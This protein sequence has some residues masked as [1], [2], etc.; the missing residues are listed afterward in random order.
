MKR[1]STVLGRSAATGRFVLRPA[2]KQNSISVMKAK[3]AA[4][5]VSSR[6]R[7]SSRKKK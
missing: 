3:A 2:S 1:G 6:K 4:E 5:Q 7:I